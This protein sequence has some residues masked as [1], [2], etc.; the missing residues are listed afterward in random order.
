MKGRVED[1][2]ATKVS[3]VAAVRA[4]GRDARTNRSK[5]LR[6]QKKAELTQARRSGTGA[7]QG[8]AGY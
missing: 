6:E 8:I 3:D 2:V 5:Q 1:R 4:A 7:E